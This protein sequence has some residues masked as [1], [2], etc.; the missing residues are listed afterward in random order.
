MT[1]F[2]YV[3][4][5]YFAIMATVATGFIHPAARFVW[6]ASASVPIGLYRAHPGAVVKVG[7]LVAVTP[8]KALETFLAQRHYLPLRVPLLKPVAA[9]AGQTVCRFGSSVSVDGKHLG[10]A[11]PFDRYGRPLPRWAGCR[12][13][14]PHQVFLMS[15][16][17]P[18]SFDGRY[19]G[20]LPASTV[21]AML[22]PL[23]V[24][25]PAA[26]R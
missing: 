6:N 17:V 16:A 2:V 5:A 20:P 23:W 19:F 21:R 15:A 13:L 1:R 8:P 22:T 11:L 18:D 26:Q 14:G 12:R 24:S 3:M 25:K 4:T 9:M 10:N 7:D